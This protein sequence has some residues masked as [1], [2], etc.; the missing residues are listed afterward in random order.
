MM[1]VGVS[2]VKTQTFLV[3]GDIWQ[4][5]CPENKKENKKIRDH[6]SHGDWA[7]VEDG[8]NCAHGGQWTS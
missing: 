5:V 3:F 1:K 7:V 6:D 2:I 8:P 4:L